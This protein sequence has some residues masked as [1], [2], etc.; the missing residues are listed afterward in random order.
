MFAIKLLFIYNQIMSYYLK[1]PGNRIVAVETVEEYNNW[2]STPGFVAATPDEIKIHVETSHR[3]IR[4]IKEEAEE[5][6]SPSVYLATVSQGGKDGYATASAKIIEHLR[7]LGINI[8]LRNKKQKV[9]IL[10]HAP[11][12]I[13]RM[14]NQFRII[15]T[16]FE[17]TKLPDDWRDYLQAA[18]L[19][20]VPSKFCQQ[21]F[22]E[23][24]FDAEVVPLGYDQNIYN[25]FDRPIPVETNQDFVFLHYNAFNIR[26]G[27]V[28]LWEA[29]NK[30]FRKDEPVKLLLKT[31]LKQIPLPITKSQY[32]NVIIEQGM[33]EEGD[34]INL[35]RKSHCFVYPARGEGFGL[36]PLETMATGLPVILP[37]ATGMTEYFNADCM[38]EAKVR[39]WGPAVYK[40]YRNMDVG[41]MAYCDVNDLAQKMRW[42]YEHQKEAK[43]KGRQAAEYVKQWNYTKT[44]EKLK[45]IIDKYMQMPVE[46]RPI[47]NILTLEEV[48]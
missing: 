19:I 18:D 44:A 35:M 33:F 4:K 39:E 23:F 11:Y 28:E 30:A 9:G 16:M 25:Y 43:E 42:V 14:E 34:M 22:K 21:V 10:F 8:E 20:I 7:Y 12:S 15:Y 26:K 2:L 40:R 3:R 17:S 37:N 1:N 29:F 31:T 32:P 48:K 24:G 5:L 41:K 6:A 27:F 45:T 38:Y 36:T 46:D 47:R 13:L